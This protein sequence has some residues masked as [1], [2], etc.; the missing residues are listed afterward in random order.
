M[1][2]LLLLIVLSLYGSVTTQAS[3]HSQ[4]TAYVN[5]TLHY[6]DLYQQGK[7][8]KAY[9][10]AAKQMKDYLLAHNDKELYY[11]IRSHEVIFD[12]NLGK[13]YRALQKVNTI[14]KDIEQEK[15]KDSYVQL[16]NYTL[17]SIYHLRGNYRLAE[18]YYKKANEKCA[19]TDSPSRMNIYSQMAELKLIGSPKEAD[20]WIEKLGDLTRASHNPEYHK[21]YLML[22]GKLYFY[23][24]DRWRFD[25]IYREFFNNQRKHPEFD[26]DGV[27]LMKAM[28]LAF[29]GYY[30]SALQLIN[31]DNNEIEAL[32]KPGLRIQIY[33][34]MDRY[35]LAL[36]EF[37]KI[38]VRR[39][40]LDTDMLFDSMTE[41]DTQMSIYNRTKH[42]ADK[43]R[44][45][46]IA[47]LF[48]I[49]VML[50]LAL[51]SIIYHHLMRRRYQKTI[52]QKN[53]ELSVAL[54]QATESDRM[55]TAFIEHVSHE[56]RTPLNIITGYAQLIG[57]PEYEISPEEHT[58]MVN[59]I[60]ENSNMIT[61]IFNELLDIAQYSS[62]KKFV[63]EDMVNVGSFLKT[64]IGDAEEKNKGRLQLTVENTEPDDFTIKTNKIALCRVLSQLMD[65][66]IKFTKSGS[67]TL[68]FHADKAL[69]TL[70]FTVT[71]TGI[72]IPLAHQEKVFDRFYKVDMFKQGFGLGLPICRKVSELLGGSIV[73]DKDY[74]DGTRFILTLPMQ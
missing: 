13:T 23:H 33:K 53:R 4:D 25:E 17:G 1:R 41:I 58:E 70:Q 43:N 18:Y 26:N 44:K 66:A 56:I 63:C 12:A 61:T 40:S 31:A 48:T 42:M 74:V 73:V 5:M 27:A 64:I 38:K 39:D 30:Q 7:D 15:N 51:L 35:D 50:T 55:K 47:S 34:M 32:D 22:K 20:Q 19:P 3:K 59:S 24:K 2:Y 9:Y 14:L 67:V 65:N 46:L 52:E 8:E 68:G 60:N 49:C 10:K 57:N 28:N 69:K 29:S 62:N 37:S 11:I 72:G 54:E 36:D 21:A 6:F 71:D 45:M 16:I